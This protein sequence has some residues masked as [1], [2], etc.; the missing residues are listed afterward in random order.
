MEFGERLAS[1]SSAPSSLHMASSSA[2]SSP[3]PP[4]TPSTKSSPDPSPA[5][6][7]PLTTCGHPIQVTGDERLNMSGS[8]NGFPLVSRPAFGLYTSSSGRSEFGGLGSLGLS[9]LAA[10]SQFG[11]FPD[12][13]RPSEAH[14]RGAAAF[15][16]P[17]LGLHPAFASTFKS[18]DPIHLQSRT[19]VSVGVTGTVNGRSASSP[20]G[21]SAVNTSSFPTKGSMEK[22]KN[23][24]SQIQKNSQDPGKLHQKI[25]Q[26]TKEKRPNKRPLE[27][28][29][30]SGSQSGSLSDSS[31][32]GEE[33]SSDPDDMEE[34]G[35]EED[36]DEDEDDQSNDSEDSDSE[37]ESRVERKVKRLTQN[38]SESK[39]KRPCTADGNTTP[40][41]H[42]E[43]LTSPHRLQSSSH[44]A[45]L[46]QS[47]ALFLQSS[48][49]AEE[50][51][52]QHIS[53]IQATGLAAGNSPLAPSH[54]EASP[55]RSRSSPNPVS[56]SNSPKHSH[57]ST[58]QKHFSH[59]SS[60]KHGSVSS[61]PKPHPLCS[62]AKPL[63]LCS[64]PKPVSLSF[65]PRPPTPSAS[66]KP[67]HKPKFLMPSLK[68]TQLADGMKESS[69]NP[70]DER[71]LHLNSFKLKQSLHSKDSVKQVFSLRPKNQNWHKSHKNSASSSSSQ[72]QHKHSSDTLSSHLLS[73][74][75]SDDTNLFLSHHLNGA[76]HSAVQDA[77]LALITKP[78]SQSSTPSSKPLLVAT[79]PPCPMPIN[80][81]TGTKDMSG[82]SASPLKSSA[83]SSLA[84][85]PRKTKTPKSLY[86][87]KSLSKP[88][89]SCPPVDLVR[90]SES[91]IHSSKDS[92]D[93]LGDDLDDDD[94]DNEDD[95]DDEDS[96]SSLSESESNLDSDSDGSEDDMK[97]RSETAAD[98][99][100]ERTP[101]KRTKPPLSSHKSTL[102]LSANCSLLNLQIV[103]PPSLSSGL[104]TTTTVSSS[105]AAGNHSTLSPSFTFATLPGPGKRRRVTDE[106]VLRLPLEFGWQRE[107]RIRTVAG[108]LQGEVAYFAPCGKKLRQYPDV[109]KYLLRNGITE[110]SRDNF[111]FSTKIKVGDFY[112]ARE[113]PE[114]LQWVLLAEEE[115]APSIIAMDGR[116][117]RC[118]QSERQPIGDG[119]GSR[120]WKSHPLSI[121][122]NSFQDVGDAKLLRKLEAQE[123]AR[124]AAQIKMMRKLEKQ[125]VAQAAK[126]ARK[127]QAI[128]AAE[129]RRK[130]REQMKILKQQEKIKRIQQI[131]MEKE[132]RAQQILEAKRKKKEEAAN[133]KILEAEKRNKEKEMRR[134]QAVILKHQEL[135]RHRL[136]MVWERERRR[137]HMMLMKAVE[138]RKK[139][140]EKERL[141]KEK[142]D[143]KR[144]NK[145][146]KLEL[147]RLELEKAKELKKP[148]EDMCLAD[149]KPLPELS[150]I[151][152]LVLPGSTF[153]DCLMVLQFLCSFGKVLRLD[154]NPNMLSLS[155]LQ[156]G[157][158][159]TGD[160]MGK[161]QDLLVSMLSA[162]VCDPGIPAGHKNKTALG[163]HLTN[164]GINR[165]NVSEILQIYMEAHCEQTEVAALA[166][167]LRTKAFQA[168]SPSQKASMLAFL[169]N[170][171][172]CSKAVISEIDKN[173]DHMTNLRKDKWVVE[174]KLRKLRNIHA[175][176]TGKR[177]SSVGGEDSHTFV[178]PTARNKGKRKDG[179]SEEE[180]DEDDDSEDQ[181]DDDDD[182]EEE[183]GGKKGKKAEICEEEDDSV[184]S[185]SMEELEKQI[186]KTY[187]QQIQIRQKLFDSSH[188]LRSMTIGQ[189]RYKRRYWV[190]PHCSGIFV[191]GMES[192]EGHEEVEK[193]KKRKR[194]AQVIRVKEEQQEEAKTPVVSSP[195]QSTD[196]DTTTPESQQDKDSLNLFLQKPGSFSKLSKLLEVAK[197]AQDSDI[198]SHNSHSAKVPTT[199]PSCPASQT[200]TNQQGLIDKSDTSVPSLLSAPQLRS[201]PWI[202][203]GPQSVLH[204][205]QLSKI[206]MEKSNQ[207]FSLLPRSPCDE[208]SFTSGSSPPA[209]SS[210]LQTISTKSP[211]SLS[212]NP[213][214]SASSSAP[215]GINN[216]QPSVLQQVKSGIHQ[217]R[218]TRC[219]VSGAAPGPSLPSSGASLLPVMDLASQHAED[220][221]SRAISL[222][223]NN[224]VNKSETPEPL[225]DKPDCASFPAV[226][227]AKTQDYPSPQPIPEEMLCGWWRVADTEELH[228]LV[229]A[230]HSRGIRE[231]ALQKQIQK[232]MEY[233][234][235]LCANSKDAFD[236][237]ELEKQEMSE[238]TVES[239]CVEEQAM[240][241]D[242]SLL[243][244]V[245]ALERKV[246]SAS[247]Q[248]K[249][250]MHPEPQSERE[251]LVY[252]EHKLSFSPAP[253]KKGQR[254]TSQEE[255]SGT[256][257]RRPDNPLDIA[258]IRLAE[259]ER[260]IERSSEE[261]V[262]PG[263]RMWRKALGEVRS[264]A[265]LSLCIQQL[266]KSIA[267]ERSIMKV[268]CQLCQKG[269]N[270][271]LLL[272]CD[273]C[274]KGCHTYCHK[275]KIT[276]VPDGDWYCPT[277][278]AKESGQSPRSR[279]QQSRTAGGGK[280]GSEVKRNSKPSVVG[281][282]IKEEA[283]SS[284]SVPKKGTKEFKKRK[285]DDSPPS[286]QAGHDS[287]VSC[288]K[289]AKTAKDNNTNALAM[290]RVLL[291]ELEAHQDAWPFLT[292]V[293]QKAVPGYRKV[294]KKPMDFSTIREK[295][296]N[297][298]YLN[299]ESFIVDVNLV[300]DNCEK[301]NE[302]DSEIG[303]AGHSMRRF[304]DK[305]WTELLE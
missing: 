6:S 65:S 257:V 203:C 16:P 233:T 132:L 199:P 126:E 207:W 24:S 165:D 103:K 252:H 162:A 149:H 251:D 269:D 38:T 94:E 90:G 204:E 71:L 278:V 188:S 266:Q 14:S 186:E 222:A 282:L 99:D 216:L 30:M 292:P 202:T 287:P 170:E 51:G 226:E 39:K 243:Q 167:S 193:E 142:K 253:E 86:L 114:G 106:R 305:R 11:T 301:F 26:K 64:S 32:D 83:S 248:V 235:Q 62:T 194:T 163:D 116:R 197:M 98:S 276:T 63:P 129:E 110:I 61:S 13:W 18:H 23:N 196:G 28:S 191:E 280:K 220:D 139:A 161:V 299:L 112:E 48:R 124:Q 33:S 68:H 289:K 232:H 237:S 201:S 178:I 19:S 96:G 121:G 95:I 55:L 224:S 198:N 148:N 97:E 166:L 77:P 40:D 141:K 9:A 247:L 171:L 47:A 179:D 122:E 210:P 225:S 260:N 57:P 82:S 75:H 152:G 176:K 25:I 21:N 10:H 215:A 180:E 117:S 109:M 58:S 125:A 250:W 297:N 284:T 244:R 296:T 227:V 4:Q 234:T 265:Q 183:S 1:P 29:S 35:E 17:L 88:S 254:E 3:A 43:T 159:N 285:G 262:A 303:R 240:E 101:L 156:E 184:H 214:A 223:N 37:K 8:S 20:T 242:I 134:L 164:V 150:R 283:A 263:M 100:A 249:G 255:L 286:A 187:K 274:D 85:R 212:P 172:C 302:D 279:K 79:S 93:S 219:D 189:D 91:D 45:G 138:A 217:S 195:A 135:E 291:A 231:K 70:S 130:K 143:E 174:G 53:V 67:P 190:L 270:E 136:D 288:G 31:S 273:G 272:L 113:G 192:G 66:Q 281:E 169:V 81:S 119:N 268:H 275:P 177:D 59:S 131:R 295:L 205:D 230:L 118:T 155:N 157:L 238:E 294:I 271:E 108:R 209:S 229:K 241:V 74:P 304:F 211:S 111:S 60:P 239:W 84:H 153:S 218:L 128:M 298:Q 105:G 200:A 245:E 78:R 2:S 92:D 259:L 293:N 267:W 228:S 46:S 127:Q 12:W 133:A 34:E 27:I 69:G 42:R 168:H 107:T 5:G 123:I 264:S 146:R 115:I 41:S 89:S 15:F 120:Q 181:G 236:V 154:I 206:L 104:L 277:C 72:T 52:Q 80:L 221:A 102:N 145:E 7:S 246:I 54:R 175:K 49:I 185:A 208:S 36:N 137:Q 76:I 22:I 44:P 73:L 258:V 140:E 160:S 158:L 50:K 173:I 144:L 261:E 87:V 147:R 290:C 300:F 213:R 182:E 56:F 256:V 151:P